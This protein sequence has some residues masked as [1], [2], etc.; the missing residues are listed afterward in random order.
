MTANDLPQRKHPAHP[1]PVHRHN[2]PVIVFVT[3]CTRE[4]R[5]IL[6]SPS[7]HEMLLGCWKSASNWK[8][9]AYVI[10]PDH[11]HLFCVP[12]IEP[13]TG[14]K[15]WVKYWKSLVA[16]QLPALKGVWQTD[17]WDT[18][19]RGIE[20]YRE[21]L[22]YVRQNPVRRGLVDKAEH[23]PFAGELNVFRW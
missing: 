8:V 11:V 1:V 20:H 16:K 9:G 15:P 18:Q 22:S 23:W 6:P 5:P 10:L 14:I 21:K 13:A 7:V 4:R 3:V 19:M 12:G 2:E 17:C